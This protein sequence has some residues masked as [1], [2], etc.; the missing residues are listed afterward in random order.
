VRGAVYSETVI[1]YSSMKTRESAL[2]ELAEGVS[3]RERRILPVIY[4]RA[5]KKVLELI[6]E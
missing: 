5:P 1:E 3:T 6:G 2:G 4:S